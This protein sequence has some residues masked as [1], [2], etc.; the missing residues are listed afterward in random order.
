MM[1]AAVA[2]VCVHVPLAGPGTETLRGKVLQQVRTLRRVCVRAH[3][4]T[5]S[6]PPQS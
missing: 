3:A 5:A 1:L 4:V 2:C 6:S